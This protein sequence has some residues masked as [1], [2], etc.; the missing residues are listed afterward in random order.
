MA[1]VGLLLAS[2]LLALGI[3]SGL[4]QRRTLRR[5]RAEKYM[6]SDERAY[7]RRQAWRRLLT[8]C[9]L[10]VIG[11]MLA[12]A[13][14]SGMEARANEIA[15]RQKQADARPDPSADP[16]RPADDAAKP[17]PSE[18]DK[19]F[20]K[21]YGTYWIVILLLLFGAVCLAVFDFFATRWYFMAQYRR[22]KADHESK[23]QRDLAVHRHTKDNDR[24]GGG[25]AKGTDDTAI[26]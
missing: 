15:G 3:G 18:E 12:G 11:G 22:I 23:L 8:S 10:V 19:Q 24:M 5:L 7:L 9:V 21:F 1:A 14:V 25:R 26:D 16:G 17:P 13:Y 20:V 6:P 2:M 4:R